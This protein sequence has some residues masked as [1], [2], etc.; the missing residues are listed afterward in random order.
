VQA[1]EPEHQSFNAYGQQLMHE[2]RRF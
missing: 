1:K 2:Q